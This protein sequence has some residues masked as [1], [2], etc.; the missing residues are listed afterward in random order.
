M[1]RLWLLLLLGA[2]IPLF[3]GCM[4]GPNF[5]RPSMKMPGSWSGKKVAA[6]VPA[7]EQKLA[8]WWTLFG[9]PLLTSL[10]ERAAA[11]NL[12]L[13]IAEAR[14]RQARAARQ[15]AVSGLGPTLDAN[16][17]YQRSRTSGVVGDLYRAG[18]D[19]G[20]EI[21][22]FGGNRRNVEAATADLEATVESLRDVLVSLSA[23]VASDYI[24]LR[25]LQQQLAVARKNLRIQKHTTSIVR[26]RFEAGFVGRLDVSNAEA[27][28]AATAAQ[29]PLLESAA[30]QTNY[31]LSVLLG[32]E[33]G[34]LLAELTPAAAV[35]AYPPAV[36]IG[37]PSDL[38]RR[39]PDIRRAEAALHAATAQIGVATADLF[40]RFNLTGILNFSGPHLGSLFTWADRGWS[41]GPSV[42]WR[43]FESGGIRANIELQKA[44]QQE[45]GLAYQQTVLTALQEVE[46]ALVAADKEKIHYEKLK[47]SVAADRQAVALATELY[48]SG[49]TDFLSVL[50]AER[51]LYV[52][53]D[54]L[55][56]SQGALSTDLVALYK[57][58]GG[59]WS[60]KE[61]NG[62][63]P[64]QATMEGEQAGGGS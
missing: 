60:E 32:Q 13:H 18:F 33:P 22:L 5:Q 59:G 50:V 53:E 4:V 36:P 10:V 35:P 20:W 2:G 26:Q 25:T 34:A 51:A 52:A 44:L 1:H 11:A 16:G 61:G 7:A 49:E 47:E 19:A 28:Q 31:A 23:E 45:E 48:R 46:N 62:L 15:I 8:S 12:D 9:D 27:Q 3:S 30:R 55:A 64:S 29:I 57:A 6:E 63:E 17:F 39:R 37:L 14:V 24:N 42:S 40:P 38:L 41:F 54:A 21:D 56:Q 43:L 58:L